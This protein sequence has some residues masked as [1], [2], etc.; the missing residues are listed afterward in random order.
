[1]DDARPS[2][3]RLTLVVLTLSFAAFALLQAMIIPVLGT[4]QHEL[5]TSQDTV[6]WVLT[7]YLLSAAV[8]TPILGRVGDIYGKDRVLVG[9]LAALAAGSVL[10]AVA[11][12]VGVLILA[13]VIQGLGGGVVPV[14][15]GIAR[16]E[17]P[18][19]RV[20]GAVGMLSALIAVGAGTGI[21]LGGPIVTWLGWRWLF[22][23]PLIVTVIALAG[24]LLFVP[25]SP[26]HSQGKISWLPALLLTGWLVALLLPLSEGPVWGWGSPKTITLFAVAV[27]LALAWVRAEL[28]AVT[29]LI[30]M[31]M[32]RLP[33]VW[34]TN[35]AALLLG[36]GMY[37][38]Y[39]FLPEFV[40]TPPSAG[41]GF[42][43][44]VTRSGLM[45]APMAVT[46][47]VAGLYAGRLTQLVGG[48]ALTV[49]GCAAGAASVAML[50]FAHQEQ[51]EIYLATGIMGAGIGLAFSAMTALIVS[52][53]PPD[54]TGVASGMNAN[55]RNIGGS[56]G[57]A[58]MASIVTAELAPSG[59]PREVGY[60]AGFATL[61]AAIAVA[62]LAALIIPVQ[63]RKPQ[64]VS[65]DAAVAEL[66]MSGNPLGGEAAAGE[67]LASEMGD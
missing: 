11:P 53:V 3:Y 28:R 31:K 37:A 9:T 43:V 57:S 39:A 51:W 48:K 13:R 7:A 32:M 10:A 59:L 61:A 4:I 42:G 29:P 12:N 56:I 34:P 52:A 66:S 44:S 19:D 6:T 40:Q 36:I 38:V 25:E 35:L 5:H 47:F 24:A 63:R 60:T 33:V 30:D 20:A 45:L 64:A 8:M 18:A 14:V 26:V 27:V 17:L 16:D 22:W 2:S 49:V 67:A 46:M 55:I 23:L 54:Q 50:A 1:M 15:F 62:A 58:V 41:Y 21:V 65:Q